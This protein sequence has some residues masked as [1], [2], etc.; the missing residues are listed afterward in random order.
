MIAQRA[1]IELARAL[2]GVP[3]LGCVE[4]ERAAEAGIRYG[5]VLLAVNGRRIRSL[6]EYAEARRL[7]SDGVSMLLFREGRQQRVE[8]SF[9]TVGQPSRTTRPLVELVRSALYAA[10]LG[11]RAPQPA[12]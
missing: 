1:L 3:V 7:R 8:L 4:G 6:A 5:D 9:V 10:L 2:E 11:K 12:N